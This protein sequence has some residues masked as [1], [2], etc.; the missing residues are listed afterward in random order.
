MHSEGLMHQDT[1]KY[2]RE[3]RPPLWQ[4][5]RG[6]GLMAPSSLPCAGRLRSGPRLVGRTRSD[7]GSVPVFQKDSAPGYVPRQENKTNQRATKVVSLSGP[8]CTSFQN[9]NF[10]EQ[11][12]TAA[13]RRSRTSSA[14]RLRSIA[15]KV[16]D[17]QEITSRHNVCASSKVLL[18][19]AQK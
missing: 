9:C 18:Q 1:S 5:R 12:W 14:R 17:L 2:R 7:Y 4:N 3:R 11:T 6:H 19:T 13:R 16:S 10:S 8:P 15:S